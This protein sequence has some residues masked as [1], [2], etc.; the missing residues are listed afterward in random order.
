[1]SETNAVRT[2]VTISQISEVSAIPEADA[3]E[4]VRV[5]GWTLVSKKGELKLGD[6]CVYFEIDSALPLSDARFAFLE[7][8]SCKTLG[9]GKRVHVLKTAKMRGVVS[10]GL[11]LP[12]SSFPELA[13]APADADLAALIGIEKYEEPAPALLAAT[14]L[15]P[16]PTELARKTDAER[17]QNLGEVWA[18]LV[19]QGPWLATEKVDGTSLTVINDGGKIRI[20]GR[21]FELGDSGASASS[22]EKKNVY[23]EAMVASGAEQHLQPGE[24]IQGE[25]FGEGVQANPLMLRG[26]RFGVFGFFRNRQIVKRQEWP[27]W[28]QAIAVPVYPDLQLPETLAQAIAQADGIKSLVSKDRLAEGVVWMNTE[29]KAIAELESRPLFKVISNKYLLKHGG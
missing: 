9:D 7:A 26:R 5:R 6:A 18:S 11:A 27:A 25:V 19:A 14:Q 23:W 22:P 21:N 3:I 20:C 28:V 4:I 12:L 1:M 15:G 2:L 24:T 29:G 13:V 16:F 17:A 8:R 10:Q